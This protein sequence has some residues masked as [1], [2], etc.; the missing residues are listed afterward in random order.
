MSKICRL[1]Q[2]LLTG[3]SLLLSLI[4]G[5]CSCSF[6]KNHTYLGALSRER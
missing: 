1:C 4:K 2:P 5:D 3:N 6:H